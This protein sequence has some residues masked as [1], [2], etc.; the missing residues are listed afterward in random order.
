MCT[1]AKPD[2]DIY[3]PQVGTIERTDMLTE[4]DRFFAIRLAD[5]KELGHMP[6]QFVSVSVPGIGEA[7]ISLSSS[8][9]TRGVFELVVRKIGRVTDALHLLPEGATVGIRGPFGTTFPV[10]DE[11]IGRDVVF[12]CGGIGLVPVRSAIQYVLNRREAYGDVTILYGARTPSDQLFLDEIASWKAQEQ[13]NYLE[14]VDR[15]DDTWTGNVGVITTLLPSIAV[16]PETTRVIICGPPIMY[17]FVISGLAARGIPL[18]HIFVSLERRMKC[19]VGKCGHC[20]INGLY[21][22]LD[23]PVFNYARLADVPEAI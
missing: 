23:G 1:H 21:T 10:E 11:L 18:E 9:D 13:V 12:I 2:Q 4:L 6:G 19:G 7:P 8:P 17:K 16:S 3:L 5:D 15:A 14:T 22:C 20:Q